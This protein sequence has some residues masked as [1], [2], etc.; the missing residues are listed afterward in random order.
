[1]PVAKSALRACRIGSP[2][3]AASVVFV[4]AAEDDEHIV[5]A[6]VADLADRSPDERLA[7][8]RQQ[9]LLGAHAR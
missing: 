1:M 7:A 9:Q 6:G 3:S 4:L 5:E 8:E 2:S